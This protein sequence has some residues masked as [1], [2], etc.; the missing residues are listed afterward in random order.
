MARTLTFAAGKAHFSG[1]LI[2]VDRSKLYG[3]VSVET[4][5]PEGRRCDLTTLA[6][7]GRTLIPYGGT[8]AGYLNRD[9][10]WVEG[11]E[12]RAVD[13][14]GEPLDEVASSFAAPITLRETAT[15]EELLDTPVRLAYR[16]GDTTLPPSVAKKLGAGTI[17][18]FGFSYRGGHAAD[19]A[20]MLADED[21]DLWL[22][23]GEPSD[24]DFLTYEQAA[25]CASCDEEDS[26]DDND[27]FD[28]DML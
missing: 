26:E 13:V 28:F 17:Y 7:D 10:R 12:R 6:R 4:L 2:K 3:S 25:L 22:L 19:P 14:D 23:V 16:L 9:G 18:S 8:A 15:V 20:F 24:V 1:E 21:N 5:D 11:N 27:E